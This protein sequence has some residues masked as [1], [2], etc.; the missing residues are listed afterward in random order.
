MITISSI[1]YFR[2]F[3]P[4]EF[5]FIVSHMLLHTQV[6]VVHEYAPSESEMIRQRIQMNYPMIVQYTTHTALLFQNT[7]RVK[8]FTKVA[9]RKDFGK[10][11]FDV[12]ATPLKTLALKTKI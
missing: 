3:S 4:I 6:Q 5:E 12:H 9:N 8:V 7:T 2:I 10:F 1:Q 11:R